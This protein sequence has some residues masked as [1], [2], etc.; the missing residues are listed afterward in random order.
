M[1]TAMKSIGAT[2]LIVLLLAGVAAVGYARWTRS[3]ADA[4]QALAGGQWDQ[5]LAAYAEAEARFD[6][7]PRPGVRRRDYT[8]VVGN[9]LWL[10]YRLQRYDDLIDKA[11][12]SP[13]RRRAAL[14]VRPGACSRRRAAR[15][16]PRRS[17]G[18]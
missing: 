16:S 11:E 3:I 14:L 13:E 7:V 18:G 2:F 4:D 5:A 9:Q 17:S 1:T 6:R 10:L 15:R 12:R 8:R